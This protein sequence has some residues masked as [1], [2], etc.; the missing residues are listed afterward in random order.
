[1][2]MNGNY[3]DVT[4]TFK[5]GVSTYHVLGTRK[6]SPTYGN[7]YY[8]FNCTC[9]GSQSTRYN[10]GT[11]THINSGNTKRPSTAT[12]SSNSLSTYHG[13]GVASMDNNKRPSTPSEKKVTS[14]MT[15]INEAL[16]KIVKSEHHSMVTE[17]REN[18]YTEQ[19]TLIQSIEK[20]IK[21]M[22]EATT[23]TA[24]NE[25]QEIL[26][27]IEK[28]K[29]SLENTY[30]QHTNTIMSS[31]DLLKKTITQ[32][33]NDQQE[34]LQS[35]KKFQLTFNEIIEQQ[36]EKTMMKH[37]ETPRVSS[38]DV[39]S[40][41]QLQ[42]TLVQTLEHH[43]IT[44]KDND[45][46]TLKRILTDQKQY[47]TDIIMKQQKTYEVS[48]NEI[49]QLQTTIVELIKKPSSVSERNNNDELKQLFVEQ[50]QYLTNLVMEQQQ[51]FSA[52]L[53][54][55][56]MIN[57]LKGQKISSNDIMARDP[58]PF[59][60]SIKTGEYANVY[61]KLT[62]DGNEC[63]RELH[64]L[65]Q[66]DPFQA[67]AIDCFVAPPMKDGPC[68]LTIYAKTRNE[69]EYRAAICIQLS[70]L[71]VNQPFTFPKL[72]PS[73]R[74]HQCILNE[75]LR[76]SLQQYEEILLHMNAPNANKIII[77]NGN[78]HI[79]LNQNEYHH[80]IIKKKIQIQGNL[81]VYGQWNGQENSPIC[82]YEMK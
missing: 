52:N 50:R 15:E 9:H 18:I 25:K 28:Q 45:N 47:L 51:S 64:T 6:T 1:M 59:K 77:S 44:T 42:T 24:T 22:T 38:L 40:I 62:I 53:I 12:Y 49:K 2:M 73:F 33:L 60:V 31:I 71:N 43:S 36:I 4:H 27:L 58:R 67:N 55:Q 66:R 41:K 69:T 19:N 79:E 56:T 7:T 10:S 57:V 5:V 63:S 21:A 74:D 37:L 26:R 72:Y 70:Y 3:F 29:N 81:I 32:T 13:H 11:L 68:E 14:D 16:T 54:E 48:I 34:Q 75:P 8:I 39:T 17:I 78:E 82:A 46:D 35:L 61:A 23:T 65:C 76:R 30:E 80:G 20:E